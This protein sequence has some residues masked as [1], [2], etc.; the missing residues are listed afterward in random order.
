MGKKMWG[1]G[2]SVFIILLGCSVP[3]LWDSILAITLGNIISL[4]VFI[5][6][7]IYGN[8]WREKS[9]VDRGYKQVDTISAANTEG[10]LELYKNHTSTTR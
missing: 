8:S 5:I 9:L 2:V 3:V 1:L 10:A 6:F 7:G 4:I